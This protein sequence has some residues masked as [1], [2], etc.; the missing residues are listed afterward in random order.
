MIDTSGGEE[1]EEAGKDSI[2]QVEEEQKIM[3][4]PEPCEISI[5]LYMCPSLQT[6]PFQ[7]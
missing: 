1:E 7:I 6:A 2:D 5:A 3:I 4:R